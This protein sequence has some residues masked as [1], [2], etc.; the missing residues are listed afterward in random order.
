MALDHTHDGWIVIL[1]LDALRAMLIPGTLPTL[2]LLI[3]GH[4]SSA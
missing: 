3:K 4:P 1:F 2:N